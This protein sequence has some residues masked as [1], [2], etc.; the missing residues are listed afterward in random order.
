ML[1]RAKYFPFVDFIRSQFCG[2]FQNSIMHQ[3]VGALGNAKQMREYYI[4]TG[5][6]LAYYQTFDI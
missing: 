2:K 1:K 6:A 3:D 5:I 4:T